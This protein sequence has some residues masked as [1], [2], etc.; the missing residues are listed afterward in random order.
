MEKL[1][2]VHVEF[3]YAALA[4]EA[5]GAEQWVMQAAR[6]THLYDCCTTDVARREKGKPVM[7]DGWTA[8]C[9]VYCDEGDVT[10][11]GAFDKYCPL[12]E[13]RV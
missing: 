1:W 13:E 11:A 10:L 7:P 4:D 2:I 12:E 3:E 9:L 8:D 6:D 5:P